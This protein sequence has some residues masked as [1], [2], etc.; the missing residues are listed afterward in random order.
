MIENAAALAAPAL[1]KVFPIGVI[2]V[3]M[4]ASLTYI[5]SQ[6]RKAAWTNTTREEEKLG[7][8]K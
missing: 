5:Y 2:A 8:K 4:T 3:S 7:K 1:G 6:A